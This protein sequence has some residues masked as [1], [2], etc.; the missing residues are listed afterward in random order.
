[1]NRT[2]N[3]ARVDHL[4][5][6]CSRRYTVI[7]PRRSIRPSPRGRRA[8]P[9]ATLARADISDRVLAARTR[10]FLRHRSPPSRLPPHPPAPFL[11]RHYSRPRVRSPRRLA[12]RPSARPGVPGA[13]RARANRLA[14]RDSQSP[15]PRSSNP[16]VHRPSFLRR[17]HTMAGCAPTVLSIG[18]GR[19]PGTRT[20]FKG[21][22]R[23]DASGLVHARALVAPS[24]RSERR[25]GWPL[26]DDAREV[27]LGG[28]GD[29]GCL[30]A[31]FGGARRR[32]SSPVGAGSPTVS[33]RTCWRTLVVVAVAVVVV[34]RQKVVAVQVVLGV[35]RGRL[36]NASAT[37]EGSLAWRSA[38]AR[39]TGS[40]A[41]TIRQ[42]RAASAA[43]SASFSQH[44]PGRGAS[45]YW[46]GRIQRLVHPR[47]ALPSTCAWSACDEDI[48]REK[49]RGEWEWGVCSADLTK[50]SGTT[51]RYGV[52]IEYGSFRPLAAYKSSSVT[53]ASS[54]SSS[55]L[56]TP[57]ARARQR[58]DNLRHAKVVRPGARMSN[59]ANG[60]N[61]D[62]PRQSVP[63]SD[64]SSSP[65][66]RHGVRGAR[67]A[68]G[69][70]LRTRGV[71]PPPV[72]V[73]R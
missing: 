52:S 69:A 40:A 1:M 68:Y 28:D 59:A 2:V 36:G 65:A 62:A 56:P 43:A 30:G 73:C 58:D 67:R 64:A 23:R 17:K 33:G 14:T 55:A 57:R 13:Y 20:V 11:R 48:G 46:S 63:S 39:R 3:A 54:P 60:A 4:R 44:E 42:T 38:V 49:A 22:R 29:V 27:G 34:G 19:A 5:S 72:I 53:R 66:R 37:F 26:G 12:S 6:S 9:D 8:P 41:L 61:S 18:E 15:T 70:C 21:A 47:R 7:P 10:I 50:T 24:S 51:M 31:T 35:V 25:R 71:V 16:A 32:G 45:A